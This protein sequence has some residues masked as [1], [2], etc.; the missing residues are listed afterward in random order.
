[1]QETPKEKTF[2]GVMVVP[3]LQEAPLRRFLQTGVAMAVQRIWC[4]E[5][6]LLQKVLQQK[7]FAI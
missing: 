5:K 4:N 7:I 6:N 2:T 3:L 1:L